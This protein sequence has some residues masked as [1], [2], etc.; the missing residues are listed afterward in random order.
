LKLYASAIITIMCKDLKQIDIQTHLFG[1]Y[2]DNVK[3]KEE[4]N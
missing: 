2:D 1:E 4:I 3:K